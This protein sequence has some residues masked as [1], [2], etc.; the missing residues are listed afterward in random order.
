[1][2]L[3][4]VLGAALVT[5]F[6]IA[7]IAATGAS[8]SEFEAGPALP[9]LLL[10][11]ADG[12]QVFTSLAGTLEC[13]TLKGHGIPLTLKTLSQ[14]VTVSYENCKVFN[15]VVRV[16]PHE[17]ILAEYEFSADG[18]VTVLKTIEIFAEFAGAKCT[19]KVL[20]QLLRTIKYNNIEN[21]TKILVS[22]NVT[23]I[24]TWQTGAGCKEASAGT[25]KIGTYVGNSITEAEGQTG[26]AITWKA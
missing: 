17:P 8:A 11:K 2:R 21:N 26:A 1:M 9:L 14:A 3:V 16:S 5:V 22:A 13:E 4:K 12:L 25:S 20:P 6:A 15:G 7:A 10:A 23:G 18:D 19:I 24:E